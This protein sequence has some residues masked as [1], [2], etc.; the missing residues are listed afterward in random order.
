MK[1]FISTHSKMIMNWSEFKNNL[2]I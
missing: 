2:Y 1:E